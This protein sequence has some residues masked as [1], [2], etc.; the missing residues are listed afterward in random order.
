MRRLISFFLTLG[1]LM[2]GFT[3]SAVPVTAQ[4]ESEI[5]VWEITKGIGMMS[6]DDSEK[7]DNITRAEY[8]SIM[9]NIVTPPQPYVGGTFGKTDI[10]DSFNEESYIFTD[11]RSDNEYYSDISKAVEYGVMN[12]LPDGSFNPE[13]TLKYE[14]ALKTIVMLCGY[15]EEA[16]VRGGWFIGYHYVA[17]RLGLLLSNKVSGQYMT[18]QDVAELLYRTID[19]DVRYANRYFDDYVFYT[20]GDSFLNT[21]MD[22]DYA[23]GVVTEVENTTLAT[24]K[25]NIGRNIVVNGITI[26]N[27]MGLETNNFL[28]REVKAF[29][30]VDDGGTKRLVYIVLNSRNEEVTVIPAEDLARYDGTNIF[31]SKGN[32]TK[33]INIKGYS[34]IYNGT[35]LKSYTKD[36]FDDVEVGDVTVIKSEDVKVVK[37]RSFKSMLVSA[38]VTDDY[39]LYSDDGGYVS[40]DS[41]THLNHI[42]DKKSNGGALL[43]FDDISTN[44]PVSVLVGENYTEVYICESYQTGTI[45]TVDKEYGAVEVDQDD[46]V[47][48]FKTVQNAH[49]N[50]K[51]YI[52]KKVRFYTDIYGNIFHIELAEGNAVNAG[53]LAGVSDVK[54]FGRR[55]IKIFRS[56]ESFVT[57]YVASTVRFYGTDSTKAVKLKCEDLDGEKG[58]NGY[59]RYITYKLNSND[60][61][62][63]I[64]MPVTSLANKTDGDGRVLERIFPGNPGN[65]FRKTTNSIGAETFLDLDTKVFGVPVDRSDFDSYVSGAC[66]DFHDGM[67]VT[68]VDSRNFADT[69]ENSLGIYYSYFEDMNDP[70]A[71]AVIL[72]NWSYRNKRAEVSSFYVVQRIA[73]SID[74]YGEPIVKLTL[75]D[76]TNALLTGYV[77]RTNKDGVNIAKAADDLNYLFESNKVSVTDEKE[78]VAIDKGDII[79]ISKLADGEIVYIGCLWDADKTYTPEGKKGAFAA[80]K[81][82][83]DQY[84]IQNNTTN[85]GLIDRLYNYPDKY[86]SVDE[87]LNGNTDASLT[88]ICQNP[89]RFTLEDIT[90][91]D[92]I[93]QTALK[94][95]YHAYR[96]NQEGAMH[97]VGYVVKKAPGFVKLTTQDLSIEGAEYN[98]SGIPANAYDQGDDRIGI[99]HQHW[100]NYVNTS[101]KLL[102]L[103]Y[104]D[105]GVNIDYGTPEDIISWEEGRNEA[106]RVIAIPDRNAFFIIND[107]RTK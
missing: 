25:K 106:S 30:R 82:G 48:E 46:T 14:E 61:V 84:Y 29:Y 26:M 24:P 32:S 9:A 18:K 68:S 99:Y 59:R 13:G 44:T 66:S 43:E 17:D 19:V 53:V 52:G 41:D 7:A 12:G 75:V 76:K 93:K 90:N 21:F 96:G 33:K 91:E 104:Y 80:V 85:T 39:R 8:A 51:E 35:V 94:H 20:E 36:L 10:A 97:M 92:N 47:V 63:E 98:A 79:Y 89:M 78:T 102:L 56:D 28:G 3:M 71:D 54:G 42:Y 15:E 23:K 55:K 70:I 101:T 2:T 100:F 107:Y 77:K 60:E 69:E 88:G 95:Y 83:T 103:E 5:D 86:L 16:L 87:V 72:I 27:D 81:T 38:V 62:I 50:T 4:V 31:Y 57:Y 34:V 6:F 37:I 11:V 65:I 105:N 67:R 1:I 74:A 22:M 64:A 49:L 40:L 73:D 58:L 45:N